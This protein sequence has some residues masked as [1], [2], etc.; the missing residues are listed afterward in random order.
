MK[1]IHSLCVFCGSRAGVDPAFTQ[2]AEQLGR[3]LA[4]RGVRLVYGGA[5]ASWAC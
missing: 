5:S 4:E 1:R 2:A 3:S